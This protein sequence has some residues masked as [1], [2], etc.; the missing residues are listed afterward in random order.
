MPTLQSLVDKHRVDATVAWLATVALIAAAGRFALAGEFHWVA[1]VA[2]LVAVSLV[3]TVATGDPEI[4]MPGELMALV[5]VPV[6][7]RAAGFFVQATPF[8]AVAGCALLVAVALDTFTSLEMTPRFAVVFVVITTMAVAGA[9]AIGQFVADTYY[10][11]AFLAGLSEL[12]W[13]LIIATAMGVAAGVIFELYFAYSSRITR[14]R[15]LEP[16]RAVPSRANHGSTIHAVDEDLEA[17]D[18][19]LNTVDESRETVGESLET[20][21][22]ATA[23]LDTTPFSNRHRTVNRAMQMILAGIV[24]LSLW[25]VNTKLLVNSA[26][27]FAVSFLP[28]ILRREYGYP[29]N[30]GLAVWVTLAATL[31]AVGAMG[32]YQTLAWYDNVTHTLSA[33]LVAG[34]GYAIARGVELHTDHVTF[35]NRFR[36]VFVVLFVLAVGVAWEIFEFASTGAASSLGARPILQQY[37]VA[38]TVADLVFNTVGAILVAT[39]ATAYLEGMAHS[40]VGRLDA[41]VGR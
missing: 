41:L 40:L 12:M 29:L 39:L 38:N 3:P 9:W 2:L 11:T 37:S 32:P 18:E 13:D 25:S 10:G 19:S 31:H 1:F 36:A 28:G 23:S 4:T 24:A 26:V 30:T 35:S 33:T 27:P 20:V 8:L 14:L 16:K 6:V 15:D 17:V 34:V 7:V 5:A 22:E 21:R